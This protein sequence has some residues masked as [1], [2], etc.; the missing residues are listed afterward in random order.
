M[1]NSAGVD[2]KPVTNTAAGNSTVSNHE[3]KDSVNTV[4]NLNI[5]T[6]ALFIILF[7]V[8]FLLVGPPLLSLQLYRNVTL[9][10]PFVVPTGAIKYR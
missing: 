4:T 10:K 9:I 3:I 7:F 5:T 2:V 1:C 8:L 6:D